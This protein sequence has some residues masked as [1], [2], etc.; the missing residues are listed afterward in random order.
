MQKNVQP[1]PL[2]PLTARRKFAKM[3]TVGRAVSPRRNNQGKIALNS[4]N[5][6]NDLLPLWK[7]LA[8]S[9]NPQY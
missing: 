3:A 7:S 9:A 4:L 6:G 2:I 5:S 8:A 1:M